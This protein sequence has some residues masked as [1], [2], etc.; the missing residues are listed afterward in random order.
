MALECP[1][2]SAGIRILKAMVVALALSPALP[3]ASGQTA[4]APDS[5][6]STESERPSLEA[7]LAKALDGDTEAQAMIASMYEERGSHED[8]IRWY[9]K[10]AE[11][12]RPDAQFKLGFYHAT[13]AGGLERDMAKAAAW[14]QRAAEANQPGAQ[15]N[16]A[17]CFEKGLGVARDDKAALSWYRRAAFQGETFAQK[18]VGVF[19]EQGRGVKPDTVEALAWYLLSANRNNSESARLLQNL[20]PRLKPDDVK[21][22][23]QRAETLSVK[24]YQASLASSVATVAGKD[25]QGPAKD[26]LE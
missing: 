5:D 3:P 13:G 11:Q 7:T 23:Q 8:A 9:R 14:F 15:Y 12:G 21:K 17:V 6:A 10:A 18:A 2:V 25:S 16:L 4:P 24:I 20:A 22:A 1:P 26:F 19:H